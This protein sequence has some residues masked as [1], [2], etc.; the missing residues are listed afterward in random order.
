MSFPFNNTGS[1][2]QTWSMPRPC[3][4]QGRTLSQHLDAPHRSSSPSLPS[5]T[6]IYLFFN[7]SLFFLTFWFFYYKEPLPMHNAFQK[8]ARHFFRIPWAETP[9]CPRRRRKVMDRWL[10]LLLLLLLLL[11]F[12]F[13]SVD[14]VRANDPLLSPK[15]VNYEG[16]ASAVGLLRFFFVAAF[17]RTVGWCWV[18][19]SEQW[20]LWCRW[21]AR[22]GTRG[23][24]WTAGISIQWILAL[25]SWLDARLA[26]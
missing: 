4:G 16:N 25:G 9:S 18:F 20:L 15:G 3:A 5:N 7:L 6:I 11:D 10:S 21:R 19:L 23:G 12:F 1:G 24:W 26:D 22:W 14:F 2:G 13:I 8:R 17:R